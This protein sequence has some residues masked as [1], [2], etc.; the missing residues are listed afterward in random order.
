[1]NVYAIIAADSTVKLGLISSAWL[2]T[3]VDIAKGIELTKQIG[4]DCIDIFADP[5]EVTPEERRLIRK[6]TATNQLPV[7]STVCCALGIA[8]FNK[9]VRDFHVHRAKSYLD[10]CYEL[11]GRNLLLV[12]G[13]YIWQQEVIA[14]QDQWKWAVEHVR[15]L[16]E[17]ANRLGLEIA[18]EL[19]PF[20]LSLI[21]N[22]DRMSRFLADVDHAAAK[23]NVDI[24]HLALAEDEAGEISKLKGRIAH[25]HLSDCDGKKHGDLPPGRGVVDFPPYLKAL[26][27]A[28][29]DGTISIELE[30]SPEPA[31]IADWVREAYTATSGMMSQLGIRS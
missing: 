22:I 17:Y 21:N 20:H 12:V 1:M 2:G 9:P 23:A 11:E 31:K 10:L 24:S 18:I 14:P 16:A 25:V 26:A 15:E 28:G 4:F 6:T 5:L 7:I 27:A 8:D 19:E 29:F 3:P 30:Y 13:E